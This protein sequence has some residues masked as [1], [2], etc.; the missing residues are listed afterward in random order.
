MNQGKNILYG[1]PRTVTYKNPRHQANLTRFLTS[2]QNTILD[3]F[4]RGLSETDIHDV[5][6]L[7]NNTEITY[8]GVAKSKKITITL[9]AINPLFHISEYNQ[10]LLLDQE[11]SAIRIDTLML[12]ETKTGI[13]TRIFAHQ[14]KKPNQ[15]A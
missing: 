12:T 2:H 8:V 11:E 3:W 10:V 14:A 4:G 5:F 13:G 15:S 9:K 1:K 6:A 7:P